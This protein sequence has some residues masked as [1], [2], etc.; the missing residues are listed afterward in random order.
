MD[1]RGWWKRKGWFNGCDMDFVT[2]REKAKREGMV[3][4]ADDSRQWF[5]QCKDRNVN[6]LLC[7]KC[8][9]EK[10]LVRYMHTMRSKT[11]EL[12]LHE[13]MCPR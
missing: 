3:T 8:V 9:D 13:Y 1:Y 4:N 5:V 7:N 6:C 10:H 11:P 12:Y 2:F